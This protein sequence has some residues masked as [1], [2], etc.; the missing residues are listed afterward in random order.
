MKKY[1]EKIL[2]QKVSIEEEKV[3]YKE[4]PLSYQGRYTIYRVGINGVPWIAMKPKQKLGLVTM[5]RDR[6]KVEKI[7]QLNCALFLEAATFYVKEKLLDEGIPFIVQDKQMYLSFGG[8][9]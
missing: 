5:R 6:I 2:R 8:Y 9:W 3:L 7:V 1:L 4:L